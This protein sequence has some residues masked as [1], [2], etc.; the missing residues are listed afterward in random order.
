MADIQVARSANVARVEGPDGE[1]DAILVSFAALEQGLSAAGSANAVL[2]VT[3][4]D[5]TERVLILYAVDPTNVGTFASNSTKRNAIGS[6]IKAAA[7]TL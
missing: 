3:L 2:R 5:D 6:A 7:E 1:Y 4:S